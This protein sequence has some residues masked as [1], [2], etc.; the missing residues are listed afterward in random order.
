MQLST[1]GDALSADAQLHRLQSALSR[2]CRLDMATSFKR[3]QTS[4]FAAASERSARG[5]EREAGSL[6]RFAGQVG[7]SRIRTER[8]TMASDIE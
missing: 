1:G 3:L 4:Q 2:G 5:G 6:G 8:E 7:V